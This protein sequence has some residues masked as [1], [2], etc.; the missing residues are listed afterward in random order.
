MKKFLIT[1]IVLVVLLVSSVALATDG[2]VPQEFFTWELLSTYAGAVLAVALITQFIK[3]AGI[4][5]KIPTQLISYVIAL[6]I[7]LLALY[8][9]GEFILANAALC[10][11][12]AVIVSLA[13]NGGFEALQRIRSTT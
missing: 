13:A 10:I 2:V 7:L 5:S 4:L 3:G 9:N 12:N 11:L 1:L 8:F 6:I